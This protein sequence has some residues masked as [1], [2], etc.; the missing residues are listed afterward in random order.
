MNVKRTWKTVESGP[1]DYQ[2]SSP[3]GGQ[4]KLWKMEIP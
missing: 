4:K 3:S 1:R 2:V